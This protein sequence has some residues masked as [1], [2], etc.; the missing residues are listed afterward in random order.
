LLLRWN[1][2][3]SGGVTHI[4]I[5]KVCHY[6]FTPSLRQTL[7]PIDSPSRT[8][9]SGLGPTTSS[10]NNGNPDQKPSTLPLNY[11]CSSSMRRFHDP[12][13]L[14][15]I[16]LPFSYFPSSY[17]TFLLWEPSDS[18]LVGITWW[19]L[20]MFGFCLLNSFRRLAQELCGIRVGLMHGKRWEPSSKARVMAAGSLSARLEA[21]WGGFCKDAV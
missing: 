15:D 4:K 18:F 20:E 2:W 16:L 1:M 21:I 3:I 11:T 7:P 13:R 8:R 10:E 12:R 6:P 14:L 5:T 19:L 9:L 17:H